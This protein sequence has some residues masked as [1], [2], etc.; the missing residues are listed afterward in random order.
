MAKAGVAYTMDQLKQYVGGAEPRRFPEGT[1]GLD[2]THNLIQRTFVEI[3]FELG[4]TISK[5]KDKVYSMTGSS[6]ALMQLI[7]NGNPLTNDNARLG[8]YNPANGSLLHVVDSD[9]TSAAK[10]G[11]YDD[12]SLV[13]KYVMSDEAYAKRGNTVAAFKKAMREKD[14]NWKPPALT[15]PPPKLVV[16]EKLTVEL[17][18]QVA[19]RMKVGD[20]CQA[21]GGRRG[22]VM[23]IGEV[24]EMNNEEG[25]FI[26][27]GIKFDEA[28]VTSDGTAK[29]KR[30]FTAPAKRGG[31]VRSPLVEAGNFPEIDPFAEDVMQEL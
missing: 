10:G 4:W 1:V 26:W 19:A 6:P 13:K 8:D 3:P 15:K 18:E 9:P 7:L 28:T 2:V 25:K 22:E 27:I 12:V 30:Y 17:L 14:P 24:P 29:G 16:E 23:Y 11:G 20:R 31:F 21:Y 5:C